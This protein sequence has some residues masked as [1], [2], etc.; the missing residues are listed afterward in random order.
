MIFHSHI[1]IEAL[2]P[3]VQC[4]LEA[5]GTQNI[6]AGEYT[7][8][9]NGLSG[10]FF[11]FGNTGKIIL[12]EEHQTPRVS[13][14]GQIDQHFTITHSPSFYSIGILLKP[15][16][17]SWLFRVDMHE[18]TN[19]AFDGSLLRDD[20]HSL[21][22]QLQEYAT[23][24][25]KIN[26]IEQYL[27]RM[28]LNMPPPVTL[29]EHAVHLIHSAKTVSIHELARH[30]NVSQRYLETQ[31]QKKIGLSPKTYSLIQRFKRMERQ[32][33]KMPTVHWQQMQFANEYFDQNHFI[34]DFRRFTGRTP[35]SYL[36]ENLEMGRS[37]LNA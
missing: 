4:Y 19:K 6:L 11:N 27:C 14:F 8:F 2:Q 10:I 18:F 21:H 20:L 12:K 35:S 32:I 24:S 30:F 17:L 22:H 7:L 26:C 37:Y 33:I 1:P 13:I 28:I 34:K 15:T 25:G 23:A 9:P 3:Y 31:F 16:V 5:D 29:V 36:L